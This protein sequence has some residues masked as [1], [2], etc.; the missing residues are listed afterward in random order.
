MRSSVVSVALLAGSV[1]M[2]HFHSLVEV[3]NAPVPTG[4][5]SFDTM[6][7]FDANG[8]EINTSS[9]GSGGGENMI[10]SLA[11]LFS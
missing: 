3:T 7:M 9:R 4:I 8:T 2:R 10:F 5:G 1:G 11:L 6:D